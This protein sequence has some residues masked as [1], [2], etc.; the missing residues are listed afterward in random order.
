MI[1]CF[2]LSWRRRLRSSLADSWTRHDTAFLVITVRKNKILGG[3]TVEVLGGRIKSKP[4]WENF[5]ESQLELH[6]QPCLPPKWPILPRMARDPL[7]ASDA[8]SRSRREPS[9]IICTT[10]IQLT[11]EKCSAQ[12]VVSIMSVRQKPFS[13]VLYHISLFLSS[14]PN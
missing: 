7:F 1:H 9:F 2:S 11:L 8:M 13:K 10:G 12:V 5:V 3:Q 4:Q 14:F 6:P